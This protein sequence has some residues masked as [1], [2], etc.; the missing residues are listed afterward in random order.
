M[1]NA[2]PGQPFCDAYE[3]PAVATTSKISVCCDGNATCAQWRPRRWHRMDLGG[4]LMIAVSACPPAAQGGMNGAT[5]GLG[6][7]ELTSGVALD[8]SVAGGRRRVECGCWDGQ[9][10]LGSCGKSDAGELTVIHGERNQGQWP[11]FP[12]PLSLFSPPPREDG[13]IHIVCV[14]E[15]RNVTAVTR[16]SSVIHSLRKK[17]SD[18]SKV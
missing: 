4:G 12:S 10:G 7:D 14:T 2:L 18:V 13:V 1:A 17:I 3:V 9:A 6:F 15:A 16:C 5:I 11:S 8:G